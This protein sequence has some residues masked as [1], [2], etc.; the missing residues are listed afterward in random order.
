M[1]LMRKKVIYQ[2]DKKNLSINLIEFSYILFISFTLLDCGQISSN[3]WIG[4]GFCSTENG[5]FFLFR[6]SPNPGV[7]YA[8][9]K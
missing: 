8:A 1:C 9:H 6:F 4:N 7:L 3:S 2:W 5:I